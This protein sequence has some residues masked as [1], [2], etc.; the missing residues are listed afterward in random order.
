MISNISFCAIKPDIYRKTNKPSE[1]FDDT[2][3]F[4]AEE[5]LKQQDRFEYS[6]PSKR[7]IFSYWRG[8]INPDTAKDLALYST[9]R[10]FVSQPNQTNPISLQAKTAIKIGEDIMNKEFSGDEFFSFA[11]ENLKK[12]FPED[13]KIEV[14]DISDIIGFNASTSLKNVEARV[15]TTHRPTDCLVDSSE[16]YMRKPSDYNFQ[17]AKEVSTLVH[18]VTHIMK[19]TQDENYLELVQRLAAKNAF[20]SIVTKAGVLLQSIIDTSLNA[21]NKN[22]IYVSNHAKQQYLKNRISFN[23]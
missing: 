1:T 21:F 5:N 12:Y 18:E 13:F 8:V 4:S 22:T 6:A 16:I 19:K 3:L 14:N 15:Y 11:Q 9:N 20:T 23:K 10:Y 7:S 2:K 17:K